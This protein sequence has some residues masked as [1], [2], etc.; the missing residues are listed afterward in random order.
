MNKKSL[1]DVTLLGVDCVDLNRLITTAT[2]CQRSF[3]FGAVK[4][5]TSLTSEEHTQHIVPI[6]PVRTWQ[7]YSDF[8]IANLHKYVDTSHVLI[9]QYDGF[10]LN[11]QAWSD[12]FL[13]YDYI[14]APCCAPCWRRLAVGN[15][16]FSLRS[17][18]L[19]ELINQYQRKI[20]G[21][22]RAEDKWICERARPML[23]SY[24]AIFAPLT[25]ASKF[26]IE[27]NAWAGNVWSDQFGFHDFRRTDIIPWL[28]E[29]PDYIFDPI[30]RCIVRAT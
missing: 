12:S 21:P 25:V 26:S 7:E 9:I 2:I 15:G 6:A 22:I 17:K 4:I 13:E 1:A 16:G 29:N 30:K 18:K 28:R 11:P 20:P 24:G 8:I 14:G 3:D 5:L 23:E 27:G 19:L 10:I